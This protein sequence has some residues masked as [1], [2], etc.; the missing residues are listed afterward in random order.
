MANNL[1]QLF[2]DYNA[3]IDPKY[4]KT[5]LH[6][7]L[8]ISYVVN[9]GPGCTDNKCDKYDSGEVRAAVADDGVELIVACLGTGRCYV[10]YYTNNDP[11]CTDND[12]VKYN[13]EEVM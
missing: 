8:N 5:P 3:D 11:C 12:Y 4:S 1:N 9:Y 7:L 6:G 13:L 2:G 10:F